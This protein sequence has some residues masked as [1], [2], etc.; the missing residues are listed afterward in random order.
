MRFKNIVAILLIFIVPI[1]AYAVLS[2][3]NESL[4]VKTSNAAKPKI[5]KFTSLMCLDC[6]RL[7]EVMNTVYPKYSKSIDLIEVHVQNNDDF[8]KEQIEKY[9]IKLVPT[10][11][12]INSK[13]KKVNKIEGFVDKNQLDKIMKDLINE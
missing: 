3:S 1:I 10:L 6:K 7:G 12:L 4:A 8:T 2:S 5:I 11:I 9:N 13:G